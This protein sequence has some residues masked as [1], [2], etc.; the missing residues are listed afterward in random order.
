MIFISGKLSN[1]LPSSDAD[2]PTTCYSVES[3]QIK[4][5][6]DLFHK[7]LMNSIFN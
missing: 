3:Q 4:H 6:K 7:A 5:L 1:A 2:L